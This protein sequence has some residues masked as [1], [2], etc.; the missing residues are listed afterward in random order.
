MTAPTL[1]E[2]LLTQW[3]NIRRLLADEP[4]VRYEPQQSFLK[5][6]N[7]G[8]GRAIGQWKS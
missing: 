4:L 1:S 5:L 7:M 8:D 3:Q 2:I 6:I